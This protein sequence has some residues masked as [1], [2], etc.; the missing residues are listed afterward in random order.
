MI[1]LAFIGKHWRR[2]AVGAG[3]IA[4]IVLIVYANSCYTNYLV[5]RTDQELNKLESNTANS[6]V[7]EWAANQ[8]AKDAEKE[9]NKASQ[10][11]QNAKKEA[12]NAR[13]NSNK[14]VSFEEAN[15]KR[16]EAYPEDCR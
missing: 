4:V 13:H 16:C 6:Q 2:F 12:N 9:A 14:N 1:W 11:S 15:R 10:A 7:D 3:I 8:N 5:D